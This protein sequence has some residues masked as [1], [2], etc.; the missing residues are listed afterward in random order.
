MRAMILAAGRG[1]RMRPL[2]D[3][4]PKPLLRVGG[5]P[6][7]VWQIQ[8]LLLAGFSEIVIN[9]AWLGE[10][11]EALLGHGQTVIRDWCLNNPQQLKLKIQYSAETEALETAGGIA[12]ALPLL[13][14]LDSEDY[15]AVIN[16]DIWCDYPLRRLHSAQKQL[17]ASHGLCWCVL[18]A[19]PDHHPE[20]DFPLLA[21]SMPDRHS[22]ASQGL[23]RFTFSGIGLYSPTLFSETSSNQSAKLAPLIDQ[24]CRL[25]RAHGEIYDGAWQDIGTVER[26]RTIDQHLTARD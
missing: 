16:G 15:F 22:S 13:T 8:R 14:E 11:F 10:Q 19:N 26:L 18:V 1:E 12:R 6:I 21:G 17:R 25:N 5:R 9:H 4:V 2:T 7:I 23:Q 3:T 24:A 20:G